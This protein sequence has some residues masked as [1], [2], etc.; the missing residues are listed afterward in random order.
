MRKLSHDL[1][2]NINGIKDDLKQ[3]NSKAENLAAE[4]RLH[5]KPQDCPTCLSTM[6]FLGTLLVQSLI[7]AGYLA[8]KHSKDAAAKKFY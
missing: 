4:N 6:L 1:R 5:A 8:F 7:F 3:M 2:D